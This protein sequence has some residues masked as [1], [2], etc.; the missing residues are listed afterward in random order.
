MVE[1]L[2]KAHRILE[3][4]PLQFRPFGVE[5]NGERIRD[6][7]GVKVRAFVDYLEESVARSHGHDAGE[8]AVQTLCR[9]LNER[10]PDHAY[11]VS[12]RFLKNDWNS[13]SYEFVCFLV[14]FCK[15]ISGDPLFAAHAGRDKFISSLLQTLGR[16][17]SVRQIYSN[18]PHFG[19]KL[20]SLTLGVESVSDRSAVLT[21]AY[22]EAIFKKFGPYGSAC[23]E[24]IC[25]SAKGG[26]AAIPEKVH[27]L[28]PA[29]V[30][31]LL[32][33]AEGD[34]CCKWELTWE[35]ESHSHVLWKAIG[36]VGSGV[37]LTYVSLRHRELSF[38]ETMLF[39]S[40][41]A[42]LGW[43]ADQLRTLHKRMRA[44]EDLVQEQL[45]SGDARHEELRHVYLEQEQKTVELRHAYEEI[46]SLNVGLEEKVRQRTAELEAANQELKQMDRLKSQFLAHVSHELRTPLTG[47]KGLTENLVEGLAGPLTPKQ[48]HNLRRVIHNASRLA[49]MI[50]D[51]LERSR[52]DAGKI[53]LA[54]RELDLAALTC[55]LVEQL[56]PL[57]L[58]KGQ[59]LTCRVPEPVGLVW[60]DPDKVS[61]ILT[62]LVENA[63]KYTPE[64]GTITVALE[65]DL[66]HW[67]RVSIK[68]TGPGIP[69]EAIPKLFDQFYRMPHLH[70]NGPKG[71]GLGLSIVKQLVE[72]HGGTVC[73]QSEVGQGSVFQFTLPLRPS[74]E[75]VQT[76]TPGANRRI[77]VVDDDPDI[78]HFLHERL[79][80]YGYQ[81]ET[82]T[83]GANALHR[84]VATPFDGMILDISMPEL[85]GLAVL[86][87]IRERSSIPIIMVTASGAKDR[88]VQAVSI[89]AQDYLLKPF[90]AGQL[91]EVVERWFGANAS[92]DN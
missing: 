43:M 51:L 26:L 73:V 77:L 17:F 18:F 2:S 10:I 21:M 4:G 55:D 22:P 65:S 27:H 14:E 46:E 12:P 87:Q 64:G 5:E 23:A 49:R 91:R 57:A 9:L 24:L 80:A 6:T 63:I 74:A 82:A 90:D 66:P 37:I 53:D 13:Y 32:C 11:H 85:D 92:V 56:G 48:E 28:T 40:P 44:R 59:Q 42:I 62:N 31:D 38:F 33:V 36:L 83:D 3:K 1:P 76:T 67:A 61:Q 70:Q 20:S 41:P 81:I 45:A 16:P 47:I 50:T 34:E 29:T 7:P 54:L 89:G 19:E 58:A 88:A 30:R 84:L 86:R 68:D 75:G 71:L 39:V 60:A 35:P 79:S 8:Q 72:M 69:S 52:I 15:D 78:R 25:Q